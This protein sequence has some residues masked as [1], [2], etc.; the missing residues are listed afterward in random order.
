MKLKYLFF[1]LMASMLVFIGC[2]KEQATELDN[3]QLSDNWMAIS[4]D[5]GTVDVTITSKEAWAFVE[6][7]I[8]PNVIT[9]DK[10]KVITKT[11]ASWLSAD[12]HSGEAGETKVT[13]SAAATS[14]GR[15][16]TLKI[17]VGGSTQ[18]V[19]IRQGSLIA[20]QASCKE[21]S[22]GPDGKK[23]L[24]KGVVT[25][26]ANTTYGNWYLNDG[27][28][29]DGIYIYGT[30]DKDGKTQNFSS[31]GIEVGDV[32][33]VEGPKTT[34]NGLVELVD[35]TVINITKTLMKIINEADTLSKE[36]GIDTVKVA[37]KGNGLFPT[38]PQEYSSWI[39]ISGMTRVAGIPTK[40]DKNPADTALVFVTVAANAAGDRTG[41]LKFK[42]ESGKSSTEME[43]T[44]IQKGSIIDATVAE[45]LAQ[46][47]GVTIYRISGII[48]KD[49]GNEYGNIYIKDATGE[50]YIYGVL[51]DKGQSKQWKTM[52]INVGD[53]VTLTTV[54]ASF[55]G[56]GQGKNASVESHIAVKAATVDEFLKAPED[57]TYYRLVGTVGT[58]STTDLYGN[59][60]LTD[61]S[62]KVYVYGLLSGWGGAK[63]QFQTLVTETGLKATDVLTLVGKR[64]SYK[65]TPQ[66]GSAF[67]VSHKQAAN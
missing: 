56:V 13:F 2:E 20:V 25:A 30:L 50:V 26:I 11:E 42:T 61:A 67:Y 22:D 36:G 28:T 46:P 4:T 58:F 40:I 52:G 66:V 9:R 45:F 1:A 21:I 49:K 5:G 31:L 17:A 12:K 57:N 35:V 51:D 62:G 41:L 37:F 63:K 24:A 48:T 47:D 60:D 59:F 64:T 16:L 55:N 23:F 3:I 65:G 43:Y 15:E 6:D 29:E 44:F 27:T 54:R 38:I 34:Y 33:T 39:T 7:D 32:V 53:I 18:F 14:G 10:N 8:W 19:T